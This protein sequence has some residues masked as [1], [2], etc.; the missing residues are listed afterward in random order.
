MHKISRCISLKIQ[1]HCDSYPNILTI[2]I[3]GHT[4]NY[5]VQLNTG[6]C[7]DKCK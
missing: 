4:G 1:H 5:Q 3:V 2:T 6:H 7:K